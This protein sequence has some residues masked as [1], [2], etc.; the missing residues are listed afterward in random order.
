[1]HQ[2]YF[3]LIFGSLLVILE[4]AFTTFYLLVIG[5]VF[6]LSGLL[7]CVIPNQLLLALI[8]LGLS[9]SACVGLNWYKR[10]QVP[11]ENNLIQ[12]L[13]KQVE[14]SEITHDQ[15]RVKY[16]GSY[17]TARLAKKNPATVK[18]GDILRITRYHNN[19]FEID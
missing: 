17:W 18:V 11:V 9:V 6:I 8:S 12:H 2:F 16:S 3:Y 19:E 4:I 13:G 5:L 15:L 7:S 10:H 1:M 14:I